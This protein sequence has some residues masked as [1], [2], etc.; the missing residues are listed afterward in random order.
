MRFGW[1]W[2]RKSGSGRVEEGRKGERSRTKDEA[3]RG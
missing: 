1:R 2:R 3:G